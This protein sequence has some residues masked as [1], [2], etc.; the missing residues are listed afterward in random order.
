MFRTNTEINFNVGWYQKTYKGEI[1][2]GDKLV[3]DDGNYSDHIE[4]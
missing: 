2:I 4:L 1:E 3:G